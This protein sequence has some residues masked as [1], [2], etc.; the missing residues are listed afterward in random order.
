MILPVP[1][2]RSTY[3]RPLCQSP[4]RLIVPGSRRSEPAYVSLVT[5]Q[6]FDRERRRVHPALHYEG[7]QLAGGGDEA[8]SGNITKE[9]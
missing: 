5:A 4:S 7:R 1:F 9:Q 3:W 6:R 8:R 2:R